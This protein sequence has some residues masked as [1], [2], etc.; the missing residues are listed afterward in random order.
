MRTDTGH[1][2]GP[3]TGPAPGLADVTGDV[4]AEAT[5]DVRATAGGDVTA[6]AAADLTGAPPVA[7]VSPLVTVLAELARTRPPSA[8]GTRLVAVDGRSG[9]GKTTLGRE[10]AAELGAPLLELDDLYEGWDGLPGVGAL[11]REWIAKP[12]AAGRPARWRPYLWA[13]ATRGDW[14]ELTSSTIVVLE[15]CGAGSALLDEYLALLVWVEA[16][17][18]VRL[19]RLRAR[20]DWPGYQ[21]HLSAWAADEQALLAADDIP[22]RA[23]VVVHNDLHPPRLNVLKTPPPSRKRTS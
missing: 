9:S 16:A 10:L 12:L 19:E 11:L 17:D 21:H 2:P 22:A 23:D 15:G 6:A 18:A 7:P 14:Q 1:H 4:T 3:A 20:A 8:G 13:T 5:A